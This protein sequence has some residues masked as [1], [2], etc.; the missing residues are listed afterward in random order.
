M[1]QAEETGDYIFDAL[2]EMVERHPSIG[3]IRGRGLM[4]G[5]EF[6]ENRETKKRCSGVRNA[7][8]AYGFEE[9]VL[10][11]PCGE[12]SM[13]LTPP[14]NISR[15]LVDEGLQLFEKALTRA[16][17]ACFGGGCP[18]GTKCCRR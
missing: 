10:L 6:V 15:A 7:L 4:I 17:A 11:L 5:I 8:T 3:Q 18:A 16:E 9:G 13:R 2:H 14:L 12:N 1:T